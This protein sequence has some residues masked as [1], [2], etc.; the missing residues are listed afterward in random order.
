MGGGSRW[1]FRPAGRHQSGRFGGRRSALLQLGDARLLGLDGGVE[2][3]HDLRQ[4]ADLMPQRLKRF[5]ADRIGLGGASAQ[6]LRPRNSDEEDG[7][8]ECAM[9]DLEVV[10]EASPSAEHR[11]ASKEAGVTSETDTFPGQTRAGG[12]R[13]AE[14]GRAGRATRR[15]R[16]TS[17]QI[18]TG[19][20]PVASASAGKGLA[21]K[22]SWIFASR[23]A[24][25]WCAAVD[26]ASPWRWGSAIVMSAAVNPAPSTSAKAR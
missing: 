2:L 12:A 10:H 4:L 14:C 18:D 19:A 8:T 6:R 25:A 16:S 11:P 5:F 23:Q 17:A 9:T 1:G 24:W 15:S 22:P 21:E 3:L 13:G 20:C 7:K 26:S